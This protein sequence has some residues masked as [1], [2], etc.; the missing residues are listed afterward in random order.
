MSE[1]IAR[2]R[3]GVPHRLIDAV[4]E[5]F[6]DDAAFGEI[7]DY[8]FDLW[9]ARQY[10]DDSSRPAYLLR[11]IETRRRP[12]TRGSQGANLHLDRAAELLNEG[13]LAYIKPDTAREVR[14]LIRAAE[15]AP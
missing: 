14:D 12:E 8:L 11:R 9:N 10:A 4:L 7:F 6:A 1:E 5:R 13:H 3:R 2:A 15:R